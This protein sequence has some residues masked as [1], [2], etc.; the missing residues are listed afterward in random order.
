MASKLRG[1]ARADYWEAQQKEFL[2]SKRKRKPRAKPVT[3]TKRE[4][5]SPKKYKPRRTRKT[6][7]MIAIERG[8][9]P[10]GYLASIFRDPRCSDRRRFQVAVALLPYCHRR[11]AARRNQ[12]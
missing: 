10:M 12:P 2:A 11:L 6:A 3:A 4:R 8:L 1:N 7:R 5:T 9:D